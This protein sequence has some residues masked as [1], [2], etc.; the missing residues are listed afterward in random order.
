MSTVSS[1]MLKS[2]RIPIVCLLISVTYEMKSYL[3]E[4]MT[5]KQPK[6]LHQLRPLRPKT[7]DEGKYIVHAEH[8]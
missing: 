6:Q 1:G 3:S 2:L 4:T 8:L 5:S 7:V